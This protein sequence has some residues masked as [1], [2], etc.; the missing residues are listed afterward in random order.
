[1]KI[2]EKLLGIEKRGEAF[3]LSTNAVEMRIL[4]LTDDIVRIRAGF[5]GDFTEES[6]SLV[7][8]AWEDR[9]DGVL[10]DYRHRITPADAA[11]SEDGDKVILQGKKLRI[12]VQ[13][14]P[15]ILQIFDAEAVFCTRISHIV[16]GSVTAMDVGFIHVLWKAQ[17]IIMDL[18]SAR[19]NSINVN[20]LCRQ[21]R[22]IAWAIIRKKQMLYISTFRFI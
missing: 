1:M 17:T 6:Y 3:I 20:H 12:V 16:D 4:F 18:V 14:N 8:T 2:I 5:D 22:E 13:K 21:H 15:F 7:M 19:A 10:K 11:M 9:M